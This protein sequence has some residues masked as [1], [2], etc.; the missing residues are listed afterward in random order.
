MDP[1]ER[2]PRP[3]VRPSPTQNEHRVLQGHPSA[4]PALVGQRGW[5][6]CRSPHWRP[7]MNFPQRQFTPRR[8][9]SITFTGLRRVIRTIKLWTQ[10]RSR[11]KVNT[12]E[13][14]FFFFTPLLGRNM[15]NF[16]DFL[17]HSISKSN[18]LSSPVIKIVSFDTTSSIKLQ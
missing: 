10:L 4:S 2:T 7:P 16:S 1:S 11:S 12:A 6:S 18:I 15:C 8:S 3:E 17:D 13:T 5:A 14:F 9:Q